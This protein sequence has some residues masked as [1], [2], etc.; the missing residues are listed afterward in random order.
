M[1]ARLQRQRRKGWTTPDGA[2]YVGRGS[3]WGNH[4]VAWRDIDGECWWV[5]CGGRHH[6]PF[7]DREEAHQQAADL[8]RTDLT[9]PGAHHT[10]LVD[11]VPTPTDAWKALRGHDLMCWCRPDLPCHADILLTIANASPPAF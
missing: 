1:P 5:S 6:G 4:W 3:K 2:I 7:A 8:Y 9:S 10:R 11:P